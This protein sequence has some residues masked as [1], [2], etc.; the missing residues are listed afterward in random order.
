MSQQSP[1][2]K[3]TP[4]QFRGERKGSLIDKSLWGPLKQLPIFEDQ[5]D[6][7]RIGLLPVDEQR[8]VV[9]Q[10]VKG[11][12]TYDDAIAAVKGE[13]NNSTNE[14]DAKI[15]TPAEDEMEDLGCEGM[16]SDAEDE[17]SAM[18][19]AD[20]SP[21][22]DDEGVTKKRRTKRAAPKPA[23]RSTKGDTAKVKKIC[24]GI[25]KLQKCE[26]KSKLDIINYRVK[27]GDQLIQLKKHTK[28]GKWLK[29]LASLGYDERT[30]Q[31]LMNLADGNFDDKIRDIDPDLAQR[32]PIDVVKLEQLDRL[33][34]E[35]L[36]ECIG[37]WDHTH[38]SMSREN[39]RESVKAILGPDNED[40]APQEQTQASANATPSSVAAPSENQAEPVAA[41]TDSDVDQELGEDVAEGVDEELGDCVQPE[42]AGQDDTEADKG[43]PDERP[44]Y[45]S[46]FA[47][48]KKLAS[49]CSTKKEKALQGALEAHAPNFLNEVVTLARKRGR[50]LSEKDAC[51]ASSVE[52]ELI[53]VGLMGHLQEVLKQQ[54]VV[55]LFAPTQ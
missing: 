54:D 5:K 46:H 12:K 20:A 37:A 17:M 50:E 51:Q 33:T 15:E 18:G 31:R 24:A 36:E 25:V 41:G 21:T 38:E 3:V 9:E 27:I 48:L 53:A 23:K 6:L 13:P 30:A 4:R 26:S 32:L 40:E 8:P 14:G 44:V 28:G 1:P 55:D 11:A 2:D 42:D 35:Q 52:P 47:T 45:Q 34:S 29:R 19:D 49:N 10:L 39:I 7:D 43:A 22:N 16:Q